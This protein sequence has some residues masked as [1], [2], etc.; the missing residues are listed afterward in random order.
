MRRVALTVLGVL[1]LACGGIG[2]DKPTPDLLAVQAA[3]GCAA[4]ANDDATEACRLLAAFNDGTRPEFLPTGEEHGTGYE[5]WVGPSFQAGATVTRRFMSSHRKQYIESNLPYMSF[6]EVWPDDE[7]ERAEL[8]TLIDASRKGRAVDS[9]NGAGIYLRSLEGSTSDF[10][11]LIQ[12]TERY[13]YLKPPSHGSCGDS[14]SPSILAWVRQDGERLVLLESGPS[15]W[16]I[17]G[18][19]RVR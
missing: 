14:C 13:V 10:L 16:R 6:R 5:I 4:P 2:A 17:S 19:H 15:G 12:K 8:E 18:L 3:L 11:R 7:G 1:L 9:K